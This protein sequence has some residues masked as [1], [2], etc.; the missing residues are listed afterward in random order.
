MRHLVA[1]LVVLA[2]MVAAGGAHPDR[3]AA[4]EPGVVLV[5]GAA[6]GS[7]QALG[8]LQSSGARWAR[9]FLFWHGVEPARGQLDDG[10]LAAY[11]GIVDQVRAQGK[12][13]VLVVTGAPAWASGADDVITPPR[14]PDDYASFIGRLAARWKGKVDAFEV[15][16]EQDEGR[17]WKGGPDP[18]G[19][20]RLLRGAHAAVK[21]ADPS[22]T[23]VLG[24]MVGNDYGFL[25][26]VYAAGGKGAFDAV[27]VHT[28]TACNRTAPDQYY[29]EADGRIGRFSFLGYREV[30]KVM[31]AQGDDKPIWMTELGWSSTSAR[32]DVGAGA[33]TVAGGVPAQQQADFLRLAYNCLAQDDAVQVGIWFSLSD[34]TQADTPEGRFGLTSFGFSP[35][36]AWEA[37]RTV[38]SDG[39]NL[40]RACGDFGGPTIGRTTPVP[41]TFF[42]GPLRMSLAATDPQG[43]ARLRIL[44]D[45]RTVRSFN[46]TSGSITW[47]GAKRLS[48][49]TH[50][51]TFVA[52]DNNGNESRSQVRVT[53]PGSGKWRSLRTSL[54]LTLGRPRGT[55]RTVN[56]RIASVPVVQGLPGKVRL[57]AQRRI[58]GR[59]RMQ[60]RIDKPASRTLTAVS[61]TWVRGRWRVRASYRRTG[62]FRASTTAWKT[63]TVR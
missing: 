28:D 43:I 15:W 34:D 35:K 24:G 63:F 56:L 4:A 10:V 1:L 61:R 52:F 49:G 45:G 51:I 7:P 38:A 27:G 53:K 20:T 40:N 33:G 12:R 36:P 3:A 31:L 29:R 8:A 21:R 47:Q 58:K 60:Y 2:V 19:Y 37:F 26:K 17:F 42:Y 9:V 18:A 46:G 44:A 59:W 48:P 41:G 30:K 22:A 6:A 54:G 16:N 25:E 32:C 23:V 62:P 11:D 39:P 55:A 5:G 14:D 50:T 57:V 13:L